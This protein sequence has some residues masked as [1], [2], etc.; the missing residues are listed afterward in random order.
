MTELVTRW[1]PSAQTFDPLLSTYRLL[2]EEVDHTAWFRADVTMLR[3]TLVYF[4]WW[5]NW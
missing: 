3:T 1:E 5:Q 2:R 4:F